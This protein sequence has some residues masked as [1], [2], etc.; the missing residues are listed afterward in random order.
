MRLHGKKATKCNKP[1]YRRWKRQ[2]HF[3][4]IAEWIASVVVV[5]IIVVRDVP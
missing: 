5:V 4:K 2:A 3:V 1:F